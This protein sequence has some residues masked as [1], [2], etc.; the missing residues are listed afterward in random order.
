[1]KV[2]NYIDK[3]RQVL[4]NLFKNRNDFIKLI[5]VTLIIWL[6]LPL[7]LTIVLNS[8][9]VHH[10]FAFSLIIT[11]TSLI[12]GTFSIIP[13]GFGAFEFTMSSLIVLLL[14]VSNSTSLLIA[15]IYRLTSIWFL[16]LI[17]VVILIY[18]HIK[19]IKKKT[20]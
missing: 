17:G 4:L 13:G 5:V 10:S 1:M 15:G 6:L 14:A 20:T 16:L 11:F 12:M 8:F 9:G 18:E 2:K 7:R 19:K 3:F